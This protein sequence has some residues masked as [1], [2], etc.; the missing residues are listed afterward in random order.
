M[1]RIPRF[2]FIVG[3]A[4][5]PLLVITG[6][7]LLR[8]P[9]TPL[10]FPPPPPDSPASHV[11]FEDF[12]GSAVCA[13]C[14]RTQFDL[15]NASTHGQAGGP[16]RNDRLVRPFNGQA[17]RFHDANV[18]PIV[19]AE[20]RYAFVIRQDGRPERTLYVE[21]V[22]GGAHMVGGGT[23]GFVSRWPDGSL[24]FLP[25]EWTRDGETWFCNTDSRLD[26]GWLPITTDLS[27]A[28]CG[29][30]TPVRTLGSLPRFANCQ[31]CH[32]SRINIAPT[33]GRP[34]ETRY[35]SLSID[36]E[37]CHGPARQHAEAMSV[38]GRPALSPREPA[39]GTS[40][41]PAVPPSLLTLD[42]DASLAVC[43]RCHALKDA[44]APSY[45]PG[46]PFEQHYSLGLALLSD[47]PVFA[48]G[49]IRSFA[50]Q[51]GHLWSD[52]YIS[53]SMT[54]TDC[55]EP[56]GQAYRDAN[57][58]PLRSRFDDG[59]CT[60]CHASK[61]AAVEEHTHHPAGSAGSRCVACHMPYLQ[62]PT[63]GNAVRY[64]R[65]DHT[66]PIPRPAFD[67]ALG[68][69][70]ACAQCHTDPT[71]PLSAQTRAWWGNL[72]PH[73]P[74]VAGLASENIRSNRDSLAALLVRTAE[75][76]A[77]APP[78]PRHTAAEV[79]ALGVL[80]RDHLDPDVRSLPRSLDRRLRMAA[81]DAN[82]DIASLG[83]AALHWS[84]GDDRSTRR[85][86]TRQLTAADRIGPAIR[87]RWAVLLGFLGDRAREAGNPARAIIAYYKALQVQPRDPAILTRLGLAEIEAGNT[88][89]ALA[90]FDRAIAAD[91]SYALAWI[92]L[93]I[94]RSAAGDGN[95]AA[96]A[97]AQ[98][99]RVDST[100][101]IAWLNLGNVELR[102]GRFEQAIELYRTALRY[103]PG[104]ADAH[105]NLA[106]A[107]LSL[108]R[109]SEA[110]LPLRNGLDFDPANTAARTA[111]TELETQR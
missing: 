28:D 59:Q 25:F 86:L 81:T 103:H 61:A 6:L 66:I 13:G 98:A 90:A 42:K 8:M 105:F 109:T 33:R 29:D 110:I 96:R 67:A 34:N 63:V 94:A 40:P 88:A 111:L 55:H 52:C 77:D 64:A 57:G 30:W 92:N 51:Q 97:Y 108:G 72:E 73:H 104:L 20:G 14:H 80:L 84:R 75:S 49:R 36:C 91:S 27:L 68:I 47:E 87:S 35:A 65:S 44:L 22:I 74:L 70:V 100:D 18:T 3:L 95:G 31:E 41:V 24:R 7:F 4:A 16:A 56:H 76:T 79:M 15:W 32:G 23:Q 26:R 58:F 12:A 19:D 82:A 5:F 69:E 10:P 78:V 43:F 21:G 53:G 99:V 83:L 50:Y 71:E 11:E 107:L 17:I 102:A 89:G 37:S 48:D 9:G 101:A 60:A 38:P 1:T 46:K 54:C 85:F 39:P 45:L 93:G 62:E 106:R 2:A